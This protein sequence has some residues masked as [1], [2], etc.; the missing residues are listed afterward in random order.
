M[1]SP[2]SRL[3]LC[4]IFSVLAVP[5]SFSQA[6]SFNPVTSQ[7]FSRIHADFNSDGR[8]DFILGGLP[9]NGCNAF[10]L[11]LSTGNGSYAPP[12]CYA[13]P[14]GVANF[15]AI[16]DFNADGYADVIVSDFSAHLH[17]YLGSRSGKLHRQAS[18]TAPA[19][20]TGGWRLRT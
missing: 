16:G 19:Q 6:V 14:T 5:P 2:Y 17:E 18:F 12:V 8:E 4:V 11:A 9:S 15:F 3:I 13:L 20:A 7:N 1:C 10:R